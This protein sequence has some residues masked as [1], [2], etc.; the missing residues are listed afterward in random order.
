MGESESK[1]RNL[2]V[3]L[4]NGRKKSGQLRQHSFVTTDDANKS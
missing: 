3:W 4:C 1:G 2:E